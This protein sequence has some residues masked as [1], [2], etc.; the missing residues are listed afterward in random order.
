MKLKEIDIKEY[1][2][3]LYKNRMVFFIVLSA[4][5]FFTAVFTLL[6]PKIYE[7]ETTV[8][9]S[10][11]GGGSVISFGGISLPMGGSDDKGGSSSYS[12][13]T[14][15]LLNKIATAGY[16]RI[17]LESKK[18]RLGLADKL[19]LYDIYHIKS[20]ERMLEF[21][22]ASTGIS[23]NKN[24]LLT[25]ITRAKTPQL[26]ADMANAYVDLVKDYNDN[27]KT[28]AA[29][30][31][32]V[33]L[34]EQ[35]KV[36]QKEMEDLNEKMKAFIAK[37]KIFDVDMYTQ[38]IEHKKER[39]EMDIAQTEVEYDK[40]KNALGNMK[41]ELISE[42]NLTHKDFSHVN[43]TMD[44]T[45]TKLREELVSKR[46]NLHLARKGRSDK[47]PVVVKLKSEIDTLEN[48]YRQQVRKYIANLNSNFSKEFV[49]FQTNFFVVEAR[50]EALKESKKRFDKE[51]ASLPDVIL[52]YLDLKR[53]FEGKKMICAMFERDLEST[54]INEAQESPELEV[55]DIA[56]APEKKS[57]PRV[58]Q[59]LIMGF[60]FGAFFG[61]IAAFSWDYI[62]KNLLPQIQRLEYIK[63][64]KKDGNK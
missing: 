17:I 38:G 62:D 12:S 4:I 49:N 59:N 9:F 8:V 31:R 11:S 47:H 21:L 10:G 45:L 15:P 7:S 54:R 23:V 56:V 14:N 48:I 6:S 30:R 25:I 36:K 16:V 2:K 64:W 42:L 24:G 43:P 27:N 28:G 19:G 41:K 58:K 50:R 1:L 20:K 53:Q 3:V 32:R 57:Y 61:L 35:L 5:V 51:M 46:V 44:N 55:L 52:K 37:H 22:R 26:A 34:E 39:L 13:F 33:F 63:R 60:M 40:F 29:Q 18:V